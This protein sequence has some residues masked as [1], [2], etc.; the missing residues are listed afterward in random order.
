MDGEAWRPYV[1]LG[2]AI[3]DGRKGS[4]NLQVGTSLAKVR[5]AAGSVGLGIG[6]PTTWEGGGLL[7]A[8]CWLPAC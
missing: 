7:V 5:Y 6:P 1:L 8:G 4:A 2:R 3:G